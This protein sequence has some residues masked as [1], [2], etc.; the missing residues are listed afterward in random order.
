[1]PTGAP[2]AL[3]RDLRALV[4]DRA[5]L[6]GDT[7]AYLTDATESRE[8]SGRAD[9]VVLPAD[10]EQV[11]AVVAFCYRHGLAI[12]ARGGGTG[13]AAG[14]VPIDGGVVVALERL[15]TITALEPER[16]R[17]RVQAGVITG[18]LARRARENGVYYPPDPG[19]AESSQLGGNLATNAG[20]PHSF[21]Y[22]VTGAWVTGL[23]A[24]LA[25]GEV[26]RL[27]GPIRK[28]V[29]G[30]DL[31]ALLV[32][33]EG[34]L[35][36][37]TSAWVRLIPAPEAQL[38]V[39]AAYPDLATGCGALESVLA[40]GV[41]P[42]AL[43]YLD[44]ATVAAAAPTGLPRG[45]PESTGFVL[46]AE[47]DGSLAEAQ[48]IRGELLELLGAQASATHAP[49]GLSEIR[50]LWRWRSA[51]SRAVTARR[52][53]KVSEDIVVPV[54]HLAHAV[55][56]T[57]KIGEHH[58]L[59]ACSWGHAGD[60]N[61]HSSFLISRGDPT[62]LEAAGAAS[63]DLF[64]LAVALGGSVSGEHGIGLT[65]RGALNLQWSQPAVARHEAI[66]A[67]FDPAGLFNPG[68]KL[69]R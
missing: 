64:A 44:G 19:A 56:A 33:S 29:A 26:I 42:A 10:T 32:G 50:A 48:R 52:G 43:E 39:L 6:P 58:G 28:D 67:L 68:K 62:E 20:G 37:V 25:P 27:G 69:A 49:T 51:V 40:G 4:G 9:A 24:V 53:G 59:P 63:R 47:A 46:I 17:A 61:L 2:T 35:G 23:E 54:E 16:W 21:K 5:V 38:P 60:G 8:I 45:I 15:S 30:Y 12:I 22:G 66:K 31:G 57:L 34:T 65:K 14:A 18:N 7:A 11:A 3:Q 55:S 1:M 41:T 13:F 36:I